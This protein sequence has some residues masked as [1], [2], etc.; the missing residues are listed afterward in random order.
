M[1]LRGVILASNILKSSPKNWYNF[2]GFLA[3]LFVFV[4][5]SRGENHQ[6]WKYESCFPLLFHINWC[7]SNYNDLW[8]KQHQKHSWRSDGDRN[9]S[10]FNLSCLACNDLILTKNDLFTRRFWFFSAQFNF[11]CNWNN[12]R[13]YAE[14]LSKSNNLINLRNSLEHFG[15]RKFIK[16]GQ[17]LL[18]I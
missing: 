5:V 9:E 16:Q 15:G 7:F 1:F 10:T 13:S 14:M 3:F 8:F 6:F 17:T 18:I 11:L 2:N 4:C 12:L